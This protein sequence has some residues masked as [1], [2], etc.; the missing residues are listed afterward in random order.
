MARIET[1][2]GPISPDDLGFTLM[3]EHLLCD[4]TVSYREPI[5]KK[6]KEKVT[7]KPITMENLGIL[8][9]CLHFSIENLK[10]FDEGIAIRE[11]KEYKSLG[12]NSIVDQTPDGIGRDVAG[13]KRISEETGV[14][15]VAVCGWYRFAGQPTFIRKLDIETLSEVLV[16]ELTEGIGRTGIKAGMLG[17]CACSQTADRTSPWF[18]EDEKKIQLAEAR[19]QRKTGAGFTYHTAL[20]EGGY[21]PFLDLIRQEEADMSKFM[22]SH[23]DPTLDLKYLGKLIDDE[24]ITL[25]LDTFGME[26]YFDYA[27]KAV[28]DWQKHKPGAAHAGKDLKYVSTVV[29]LCE[30]GY[31]RNIVLSQDICHRTELKTYGGWGYTHLIENIIP[32]LEYEGVT[33]KQIQ[34]MFV[35]NPKRILAY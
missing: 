28:Y 7:F 32:W 12:G 1:V 14:N 3:H 5:D 19:A 29:K 10:M 22:L 4:L 2:R 25:S 17:E 15:I 18:H 24:G 26:Y 11:L 21:E 9:R 31:D 35:N 33:K 27:L 8:R 23:V 16:T 34:N 6:I 30:L 13:L 20:W